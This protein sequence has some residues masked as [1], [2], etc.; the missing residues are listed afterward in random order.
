MPD[1][2]PLIK[3]AIRE[4]A[5]EN[6]QGAGTLTFEVLAVETNGPVTTAK[7]RNTK[8]WMA[9]RPTVSDF[10]VT[11]D[12]DGVRADED[13]EFKNPVAK[14]TEWISPPRRYWIE[15]LDAAVETPA[16]KFT[17]CLR[18]AYLIAEGDGGSGERH[19]A[20]GVGLVKVVDNDEGEPFTWQLVR[21]V[22]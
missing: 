20:P 21:R 1:F 17:G 11:K 18:V 9:A 16:G 2:F 15:A 4:Y 13:V 22:G 3:G 7:C 10:A 8:R 5:I 19:Y 12:A 6:A 14:G